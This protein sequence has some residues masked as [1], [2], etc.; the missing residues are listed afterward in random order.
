MNIEAM[1]DPNETVASCDEVITK[2]RQDLSATPEDHPDRFKQLNNLAAKLSQRFSYTKKFSDL[3][4]AFKLSGQAIAAAPEGHPKRAFVLMNHARNLV[5]RFRATRVIHNLEEAIKFQQQAIAI[6]PQDD[7]ARCELLGQHGAW[8]HERYCVTKDLRDLEEMLEICRQSVEAATNNNPRRAIL[9]NNLANCLIDKILLT[10][11]TTDL[12]KTIATSYQALSASNDNSVQAASLHT[13]AICHGLKFSETKATDELQ[14]AIQLQQQAVALTPQHDV[15]LPRRLN[16]LGI[17]LGKKYLE[18]RVVVDLEEAIRLCR[19]A[20]ETTPKGDPELN[21]RKRDL[22][23]WIGKSATREINIDEQD[24]PI[25]APGQVRDANSTRETNLFKVDTEMASCLQDLEDESLQ[26]FLEIEEENTGNDPDELFIYT[27]FLIFSRSQNIEYLDR[28]I[29]RAQSWL[30]STPPEN[31]DRARRFE[32]LNIAIEKRIPLCGTSTG[33]SAGEAIFAWLDDIFEGFTS[34]KDVQTAFSYALKSVARPEYFKN[35]SKLS[36]AMNS[37]ANEINESYEATSNLAALNESIQIHRYSLKMA[38]PATS[39]WACISYNLAL[40]FKNRAAITA[41]LVDVNTSIQ[42]ANQAASTALESDEHRGM[43]L[44]S[45]G[46]A[47]RQRFELTGA[48][49]DLDE[50]VKYCTA[51]V[52]ACDPNHFAWSSCFSSLANAL[53]RRFEMTGS[54]EDINR[55]VEVVGFYTE[56][57]GQS[58]VDSISLCCWLMTRSE[59]TGSEEDLDR[60]IE[61]VTRAIDASPEKGYTRHLSFANL[62][63][64]HL[65]RFDNFHSPQSLDLAIEATT[66]AIE[67]LPEGHSERSRWLSNLGVMLL[68]RSQH[69]GSRNDLDS[70]IQVARQAVGAHR[71]DGRKSTFLLNLG[72]SLRIRYEEYGSEDDRELCLA[73]YMGG[74][75]CRDGPPAERVLLAKKASEILIAQGEWPKSASFLKAAVQLLPLVSPRAL[76]NTDKQY[77]LGT[78]AGLTS[79]AAAASLNAGDGPIDALQLLEAGRGIISSSVMDMRID[80]SELEQQHPELAAKFNALREV[81][82]APREETNT[83]SNDFSVSQTSLRRNAEQNLDQ[84]LKEI[85]AKPGHHDFLLPPSKEELLA[86]A[87]PDPIIVVNLSTIRS[88]AFIIYRSQINL[89]PLPDLRVVDVQK[90]SI[91]LHPASSLRTDQMLKWLWDT[92][93]NPILEALA[94]QEP[95]HCNGQPHIWWIPTGH[96]SRFPLH[97]AGYHHL[98]SAKSVL[99]VVVSSYASSVKALLQGR[100]KSAQLSSSQN[101]DSLLAVTMKHTPGLPSHQTLPFVEAE[102]DMLNQTWS[103]AKTK[104]TL[105]RPP[106][107]K[108]EVLERMPSTKIFHFAGHGSSNP[109]EPSKSCLLLEDWQTDPLTVGDLRDCRFQKDPPFLGY[110]SACSTGANKAAGLQDEGIHLIGALQLAGFQNVVGTLWE[111][112]DKHCVDVARVVYQTLRDEGLTNRAVCRGLHRAQLALRD[113]EIRR[114]KPARAI[115]AVDSDDESDDDRNWFWIPY[116][117]Y[118]VI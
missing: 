71:P 68:R 114:A 16:N 85:R 79:N 73:S 33:T 110:L 55:A 81:L 19:E 57:G 58:E 105:T 70:A 60:A 47:F 113:A 107:R 18:T 31:E 22:D 74:W 38:T 72:E 30:S 95:P 112:S 32:I 17:L 4:E 117:H 104:M 94:S 101:H 69:N 42:Y 29:R 11:D 77:R 91:K 78:Y 118:G 7:P 64:C 34:E 96:L 15:E 83:P 99:D 116:V 49:D 9:L 13:L 59:R 41:S 53:G 82:D 48:I 97:A 3:E 14:K 67:L 43:F 12:E 89:V 39:D 111:V 93:C 1:T 27:C 36:N 40:R 52:A 80:V 109:H 24:G 103:T 92:T 28:A 44:K 87:D 46:S 108:S 65:M 62:G 54:L 50:A 75:D 6:T 21:K 51:A 37:K 84:V 25:S 20:V 5:D 8:L 106:P 76:Q 56:S 35:N 66:K 102:W 100:R 23:F 26:Y 86:A 63:R 90:W 115:K 98:K 88:D 10:E 61:V 45:L 2:F